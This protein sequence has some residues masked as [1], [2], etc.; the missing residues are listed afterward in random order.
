MK[1]R[2]EM[3][4]VK[5]L[6]IIL[7]IVL[8]CL[9]SFIGIY[10]QKQNLMKNIIK[11]YDLGMNIEGYREVRMKA[12]EKEEITSEKVQQVKTMI[13]KRLK[14][15]G[16]QDYL[17]KADYLTGEV[18][19]EL[20]ETSRT[21]K[22]VS[23]IYN[24]GILKM[25]DSKDH[26]K[27][28]MTNDDIEKVS[29]L[30]STTEKGT[31]IYLDMMF[32]EEGSKKIEQLSGNEY[33]TLEKE[34]SEENKEGEAE[35][36][37]KEDNQPKLALLIDDTELLSS[38]FDFQVTTGRLQL[39]LGAATT[40]AQKIQDAVN[41]GNAIA[42]ILNNGPLPIKYTL[43]G[44]TY[45]YS[46]ITDK[47]VLAFVVA[48]AAIILVALIILVVKYK[49][50]AVLAG[51]SYIGFIALYLLVLR[52]ANVVIS[53]E[54]IAGILII[55]II[56][57]LSLQKLL[58]KKAITE[59]FKEM[60]IQLIPVIAVII[61]FSFIRWTNIASFGMTMFWG[62]LLTA[63]YHFVVTKALLEK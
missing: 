4:K 55:L 42:S 54:G 60:G 63:I 9:I 3:K 25:V 62:L 16:A 14:Q 45:V 15:L 53:L 12:A 43:S 36:T 24:A 46:E 20:E 1:G 59:A 8:L 33:K 35:D 22:I 27:V 52:Y 13:E 61:A 38:S 2:K 19:L 18:V 6:T 48:M 50:Q 21:D 31:T 37:K 11:D 58:T 23:D 44:N 5:K 7:A 51:I 28:L 49:M 26:D 34:E 17:I 56:N 30:Y 41:N 57:Y 39:T 10:V 32:T 47:V 40:N 29:V